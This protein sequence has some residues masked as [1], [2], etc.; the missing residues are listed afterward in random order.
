MPSL[1][2]FRKECEG[3]DEEEGCLDDYP[4]KCPLH[5]ECQ[6]DAEGTD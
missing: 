2:E 6:K 4:E 1:E 5:G 3:W